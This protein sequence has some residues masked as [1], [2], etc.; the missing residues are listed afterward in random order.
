MGIFSLKPDPVVGIDISTTAIK[1]LELSRTGKSYKVETYGVEPLPE[2]II[3][4]K[5]LNEAKE[6][7]M[8]IVGEAIARLV[9]RTKPKARH[10][11]IAVAGPAVIT[12]V[13]TMDGGMTDSDMKEQIE[14]DAE[15]YLGSP[16]DEL[17]LDF[18]VLGP[19][20]KEPERM[21][22]L[23]AASRTENID[24]RLELLEIG[25]LKTKVV[26]IEKYALENALLMVA[27]NEQEI[28][29]EDTIALIEIGA[30]VTSLSV[31]SKQ[32]IVYSQEEMFGGKQLTDEIRSTYSISYE[33]ANLAK[34]YEGDFTLP[35]G[36]ESEILEPF[37]V[38]ITQQISR[39][40]Q[41]YYSMEASSKYGKLTH[42]ILS[43]GTTCIPG[44]LEL[45][46]NKVGGSI[47]LV[48]PFSAMNVSTRVSKKALMND[49]PALMIACGLALRNFD[50]H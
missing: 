31:M 50:E 8:E 18:Q 46:K 9:A 16:A 30:S 12:K 10:A 27:Q 6:N 40:V 26:D 36:Y 1:L 37:K 29:E 42:I 11:A 32:R 14:G 33:E 22:I 5:N 34:R 3:V 41:Y 15:Q 20:E 28:H 38:E 25:G 45:V 47:S 2:D 7:A 35:E 48:N 17:N 39:M 49:A 21:D 24:N 4:D 44:I 13:I 43:G 19:N 23:L